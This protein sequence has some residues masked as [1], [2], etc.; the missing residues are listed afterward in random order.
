MYVLFLYFNLKPEA[1]SVYKLIKGILH[2]GPFDLNPMNYFCLF[3][4]QYI[5]GPVFY[6]TFIKNF[7]IFFRNGLRPQRP[8]WQRRRVVC[9]REIVKEGEKSFLFLCVVVSWPF[10]FYLSHEMVVWALTTLNHV[11]R[12]TCFTW[13]LSRAKIMQVWSFM[14]RTLILDIE[15]NR[16][17]HA[18]KLA[19][20]KMVISILYY[21]P[22]VLTSM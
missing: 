12:L 10:Y 18:L 7:E 21:Y 15:V 1:N 22:V 5:V 4:N 13:Y 19:Q 14:S 2:F 3:L 9:E 8:K 17:T 11:C 20:E 6:M 16:F